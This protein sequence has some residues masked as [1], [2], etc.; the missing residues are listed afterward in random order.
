MIISTT[1][2]FAE[3]NPPSSATPPT[4]EMG[5]PPDGTPPDGFGGG[6]GTPPNG[7]KEAPQSAPN[8][9]PGGQQN[10]EEGQLGSWSMGGT[11][12]DSI[13]GDDY[14]Y[15]AALYVTADGIDTEKSTTDRITSGEYDEKSMRHP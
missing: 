15:D 14:A 3:G 1:A 4:G 7:M 12:A 13:G 2:S 8:G 9:A 6:M 11:D 10:Q 5:T